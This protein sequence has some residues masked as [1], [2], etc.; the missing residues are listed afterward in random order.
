MDWWQ[1]NCSATIEPGFFGENLTISHCVAG[2][3]RWG[4]GCRRMGVLLLEIYRRPRV[5]CAVLPRG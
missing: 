4:I 1:R 5:P 3:P 2:V